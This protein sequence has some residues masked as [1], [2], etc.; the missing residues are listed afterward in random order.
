VCHRCGR[1]FEIPN[2]LKIH[3]A[4]DC[5][6]LDRF[7]LWKR[8]RRHFSSKQEDNGTRDQHRASNVPIQS[9]SSLSYTTTYTPPTFGFKFELV[10]KEDRN[11]Y[12]NP[13]GPQDLSATSNTVRVSNTA[14]SSSVNKNEDIQMVPNQ[15]SHSVR[16]SSRSIS[17]PLNVRGSAF[18]PYWGKRTGSSSADSIRTNSE[19]E[20]TAS[21]NILPNSRTPL[22]SQ[23]RF[24]FHPPS[25][26]SGT[27]L[28]MQKSSPITGLINA[29]SL[30]VPRGYHKQNV[31]PPSNFQQP[32]SEATTA[33]FRHAAEMETLVSNLGRSKQGHLCIYCGKIYSR[34][35]G[36]KIHIR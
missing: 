6:R 5:D 20:R 31:L 10:S 9:I 17:E 25:H 15:E 8:L 2:P 12:S 11:K 22:L 32:S 26:F 33:E 21:V 4:L 14:T 7:H 36:L 16:Q 34:K 13:S 28:Q 24:L 27:S 3:L 29:N 18:K 35:Y 30:L 19:N 23:S 1:H